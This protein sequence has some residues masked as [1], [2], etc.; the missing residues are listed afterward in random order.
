MEIPTFPSEHHS[1][2]HLNYQKIQILLAKKKKISKLWTSPRI[3]KP[4]YFFNSQTR[5]FAKSQLDLVQ[6]DYSGNQGLK[7]HL[8][9]CKIKNSKN[10]RSSRYN[11]V[12]FITT[13]SYEAQRRINK[14]KLCRI[15]SKDDPIALPC[16][17]LDNTFEN[18]GNSKNTE[19]ENLKFLPGQLKSQ[20]H[21]A[22]ESRN[23]K[24]YTY[25]G[26]SLRKILRARIMKLNQG[27]MVGGSGY[28][29]LGKYKLR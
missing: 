9:Y 8:K 5:K 29:N 7:I 17:I 22:S 3:S 24:N 25:Q 16:R 11:E 26:P 23:Y 4:K 27:R 21:T 15:C 1:K 13:T 20:N 6:L 10:L 28:D 19:G 18:T 14:Y 2:T 12:N